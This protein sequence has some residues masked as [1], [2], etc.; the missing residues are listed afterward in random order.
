MT[1]Q[2]TA[3]STEIKQQPTA[4]T[5]LPKTG[6]TGHTPQRKKSAEEQNT[7]KKPKNAVKTSKS[8]TKV[9]VRTNTEQRHQTCCHLG[10]VGGT[11]DV[12]DNVSGSFAT[13]HYML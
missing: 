8:P 13:D 2:S 11:N 10:D 7:T 3:E 9:L 6:E 1:K 4:S 5:R 12:Y